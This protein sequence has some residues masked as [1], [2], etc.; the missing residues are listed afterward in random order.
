MRADQRSDRA[1]RGLFGSWE[2]ACFFD[3]NRPMK[4]S[5]RSWVVVGGGVV[6]LAALAACS[7][8][9]A[10]VRGNSTD[11]TQPAPAT[12]GVSGSGG[13]GSGSG[14]GAAGTGSDGGVNGGGSADGAVTGPWPGS[15]L[16]ILPFA[17]QKQA[18]GTGWG[19]ALTDIIRHIPTTYGTQYDVPDD[20]IAWGNV[21]TLGIDGHLRIYEN[22]TGQRANGFY[23]LKDRFAL[24]VEPPTTRVTSVA[25]YVPA[26]L[27][28]S[29]FQ[30]YLV[31]QA[32]TWDDTPTFI[33]DQWNCE[34]NGSEVAVELAKAGSFPAPR[35]GVS[36]ALEF[37]VYSL[38]LGLAVETL[39]ASYLATYTQFREFLAWEAE[40][41]MGLYRAGALLPSLAAATQDAYYAAW[42]TSADGKALRNFAR[43][44]FNAAYVTKVLEI[45]PA[46]E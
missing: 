38:A 23:L 21:G 35:D 31:D 13:G 3:T 30:S 17:V 18:S 32:T 9:Y 11:A 33:L 24:V 15:N 42:K 19:T 37:T 40:R 12:P 6:A 28:G 36:G 14:N 26:S 16:V 8:D 43:R 22:V 7:G 41:A 39:D 1:D 45:A 10:R 27:R 46:T 5:P 2:H 20:F 25:P 29:R 34:T 44:T 4:L